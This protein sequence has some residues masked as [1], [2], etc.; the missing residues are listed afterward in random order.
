M[1]SRTIESAIII[2]RKDTGL[3]SYKVDGGTND[4]CDHGSPIDTVGV[5]VV[6]ISFGGIEWFEINSASLDDV[7]IAK[8]DTGDTKEEDLLISTAQL[9]S[10]GPTW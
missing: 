7:V 5:P 3:T 4:I 6:S 10:V 8:E 1:L 9:Y 2:A